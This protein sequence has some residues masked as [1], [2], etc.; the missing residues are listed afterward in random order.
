MKRAQVGKD[1]AQEFQ[2]AATWYEQEQEGLGKRFIAAFENA[3]QLLEDE[4]PPLTP[5]QG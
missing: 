5:V 2:E 1:A 3:L 4:N